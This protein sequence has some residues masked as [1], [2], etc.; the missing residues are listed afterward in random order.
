M[1]EVLIMRIFL[2]LLLAIPAFA[3]TSDLPQAR[4]FLGKAEDSIACGRAFFEAGDW[5]NARMAFKSAKEDAEFAS[6]L[7][8]LEKDDLVVRARVL[9]IR[10]IMW[11]G[12]AWA[13]I[14]R[15]HNIILGSWVRG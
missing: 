10:A 15:G 1:V 2:L 6:E 13:E 4:R 5:E 7:V 8:P 11:W 9:R 3:Q 14:G 12:L